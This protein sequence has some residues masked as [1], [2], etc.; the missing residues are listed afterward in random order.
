M[1]VTPFGQIDVKGYFQELSSID[2]RL[3]FEFQLDQSYLFK[4]L[5]ELKNI[6]NIYGNMNGVKG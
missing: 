2:N 4:T 1:D 3:A 5:N 6:V